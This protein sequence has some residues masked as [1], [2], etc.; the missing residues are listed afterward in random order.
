MSKR[1]SYVFVLWGQDFN[2]VAATIFIT[3]FRKAGLRVKV[4]ALTPRRLSGAHG[5]SL[6]TDMTL[7]QALRVADRAICVVLPGASSRIAQLANDPRLSE[8]FN[9]A[10]SNGAQFITGQMDNHDM[11]ELMGGP[12]VA[13]YPSRDGM[14]EFAEEVAG[15]LR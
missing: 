13:V 2:E 14:L 7:E 15:G 8:F 11:A 3:E 10:R 12:N 6:G 4:V 9:L 1:N 5:L